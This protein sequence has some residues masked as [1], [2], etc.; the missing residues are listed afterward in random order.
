[1]DEDVS[2]DRN[3]DRLPLNHS[4]MSDNF[5]SG[6]LQNEI[7]ADPFAPRAV[8]P[9]RSNEFGVHYGPSPHNRLSDIQTIEE[10][11]I[12]KGKVLAS[13]IQFPQWREIFAGD[14]AE[15]CFDP[16]VRLKW[17]HLPFEEQK[18]FL[19]KCG[20][21][22]RIDF[23]RRIFRRE[24]REDSLEELRQNLLAGAASSWR[25]E[26]NS[27]QLLTDTVDPE[28][29]A[30]AREEIQ[31]IDKNTSSEEQALLRMKIEAIPAEEAARILGISSADTFR[32]R[33]F[34]LRQRLK[35]LDKDE[36]DDKELPPNRGM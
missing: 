8:K 20:A 18:W 30:I 7:P 31:K 21:N 17:E 26:V 23:L 13:S 29:I 33:Y 5:F 10:W 11:I 14:F 36:T 2:P 25:E 22:L 27:E 32:H 34:N 9:T 1:M 12:A 24:A 35:K 19:G 16:A 28:R 6:L 15:K 3:E 4:G